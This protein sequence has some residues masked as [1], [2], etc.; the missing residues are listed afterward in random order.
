[1]LAAEDFQLIGG[2]KILLE[3]VQLWQPARSNGF[4]PRVP[5]STVSPAR[6]PRLLVGLEGLSFPASF[7][8]SSSRRVLPTINSCTGK[9]HGLVSMFETLWCHGKEDPV[10]LLGPNFS[11]C[12]RVASSNALTMATPMSSL[13][14]RSLR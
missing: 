1:M 11:R 8:I 4:S 12:S 10:I 2:E 14:S 13:S 6:E 3:F 7:R 5:L 9:S